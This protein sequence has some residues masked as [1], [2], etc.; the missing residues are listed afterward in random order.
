MIPELNTKAELASSHID[1]A[2]LHGLVC[3]MAAG[4]PGQFSLPEL[5]EYAGADQLTDENSVQDFVIEALDL[6]H[7]QDMEFALLIPDD[8]QVLSLRLA[9]LASWCA[10][11][12]SG[13][14]AS[15]S[16]DVSQLPVDVQ[17]ILRDFAS[18][19]GLDEDA[20]GSEQDEASF[21]EI[22]EYVR[23]ASILTL[24]LMGEVQIEA[25]QAE[26]ADVDL[27]GDDDEVRH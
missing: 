14:G 23:V 18:I 4:R 6:L 27:S 16:T 13:F 17:E 12:L 15:V 8:E 5:I 22:Y 19:S 26:D 7:A 10:A 3:G 9:G 25:E 11:F 24:A 20:E 2:E 21:M 1:P